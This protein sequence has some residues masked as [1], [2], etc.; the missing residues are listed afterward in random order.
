MKK[1]ILITITTILFSLQNCNAN[2]APPKNIVVGNTY[3][4]ANKTAPAPVYTNFTDWLRTYQIPTETLLYVC[5]SAITQ[6]N[7]QIEEIQFK[8]GTITFT[9]YTKEFIL[10]TAKKDYKNSFV[11]ILPA[12]NN[13]NFSPTTLNKIFNYVD[14][15]AG[16]GVQNVI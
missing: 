16:L 8:T 11:K 4:V 1:K 2:S 5:L 9:A 13:Y 10:V 12:D 15:N 7:Y 6:N 14:L 3:P